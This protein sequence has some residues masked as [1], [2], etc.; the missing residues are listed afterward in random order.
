MLQTSLSISFLIDTETFLHVY[1]KQRYG[2]DTFTATFD[3][4]IHEI[5]ETYSSTIYMGDAHFYES[6]I[7]TPY[8]YFSSSMSH[9][10]ILFSCNI[11]YCNL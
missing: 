4:V 6:N 8:I 9:G 10:Y 3:T 5:S 1:S 11:I 2:S 7:L